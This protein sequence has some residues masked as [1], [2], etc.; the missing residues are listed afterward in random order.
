MRKIN[1]LGIFV[2]L[3]LIFIIFGPLI[4]PLP[5][6]ENIV[7]IEELTYPKSNFI[8]TDKVKIHFIE[9]ENENDELIILLHGFG[10]STYSWHKVIEPLSEFGTVIAYDRPG[11]GLSE[12]VIPFEDVDFN[13][14]I[15]EYQVEIINQIIQSK[16]P[17]K[18][19]LVGNSA[20]GT[21]AIQSALD[22]PDKISGLILISPAVYGSGGAPGWIKPFLNL[23]QF[24]RLG[25][26]FVRTIR[27]RGLELLKL[28]WANPE[29]ITVEDLENYQKPL[30]VEKWDIG[31]WEFTKVNGGNTV[32][33]R[34]N[35]LRM[36][37][38][39]ITGSED[40]IIPVE[41]STQLA[42]ELNNS[43][44]ILIPDCGHVPQEEC[45]QEFLNAT[46]SFL[47]SFP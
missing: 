11:F 47:S 42:K 22:Y 38:L 32:E 18:V 44:Y 23:P 5:P 14:Y 27:E 37:I 43:E 10:S 7:P 30:S 29:N 4:V 20:G 6:L 41:L 1:G 46:E 25:P 17:E 26:V 21:V 35:E 12:R 36:P 15:F 31:L 40:K 16:N 39:I 34:L 9:E 45:P 2:I 28:A 13:P 3:M 19:I 33:D 24:D 8:E